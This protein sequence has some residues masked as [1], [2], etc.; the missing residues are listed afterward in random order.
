[1]LNQIGEESEDRKPI[2]EMIR[3]SHLRTFLEGQGYRFVA[4]SSGYSSTEIRDADIYVKYE[5]ALSEFQNILL[6]TTPIPWIRGSTVR[7][8][9]YDKHRASVMHMFEELPKIAENPDPTFTFAHFMTP[10]WP[11]VFDADGTSH[12]PDKDFFSFTNGESEEYEAQYRNQLTFVNKKVTEM[13]DQVLAE[14]AEPPIIVLQSDHG[15]EAVLNWQGPDTQGL[16]E[17]MSILNAYYLPG[18]GA[19]HLYATITPVNSFRIIL[20]HYF[21]QTLQLLTDENFYSKPG[22]EYQLRNITEELNQL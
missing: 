4:F 9:Q 3:H 22:K 12:N 19:Q 7:L 5:L 18:N 2:E 6:N 15:P 16:K 21:G 10:R 17:R 13:I 8:H 14:S 20:N 1:V 11:F